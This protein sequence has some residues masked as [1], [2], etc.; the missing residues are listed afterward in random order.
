M[1][2]NTQV[3]SRP[4]GQQPPERDDAAAGGEAA[5]P[6]YDLRIRILNMN[7]RPSGGLSGSGGPLMPL[8]PQPGLR[9]TSSSSP[10]SFFAGLT[11]GGPKLFTAMP[12]APSPTPATTTSSSRVPSS[13]SLLDSSDRDGPPSLPRKG[14]LA[15]RVEERLALLQK[16]G[17]QG[18]V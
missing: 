4:S 2:M 18:D 7:R 16:Q 12:S 17:S 15:S 8:S 14:L 10:S 13:D 1:Y 5:T 11:S 3:F 6:Y 9:R